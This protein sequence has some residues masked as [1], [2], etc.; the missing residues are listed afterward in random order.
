MPSALESIATYVGL[1]IF[2]FMVS[3]V[4]Y[5]VLRGFLNN[6]LKVLDDLGYGGHRLTRPP[7]LF[8][9]I[10]YAFE[11]VIY[12][13]ICA[14]VY[15]FLATIVYRGVKI[16]AEILERPLV[17]IICL[18]VVGTLSLYGGNVMKKSTIGRLVTKSKD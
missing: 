5:E 6:W 13:G 7:F 4:A 18:I 8:M 3:F 14:V 15:W 1:Y 10:F 12:M 2:L 11:H 9:R 16:N 17:G